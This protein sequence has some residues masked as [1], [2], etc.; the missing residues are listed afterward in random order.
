MK[1]R[2]SI[3]LALC[4]LCLYGTALGEETTAEYAKARGMNIMELTAGLTEIYGYT[5]EE[6]DQF[7]CSVTETDKYAGICA[8]PGR[9]SEL[10]LYPRIEPQKR[11]RVRAASVA[12]PLR[13]DPPGYEGWTA[14]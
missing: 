12:L 3:W 4:L 5:Q 13:T 7:L 1:R 11:R 2:L 10:A 6:A 14:G 8:L 9:A